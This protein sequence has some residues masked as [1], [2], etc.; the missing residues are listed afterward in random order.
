LFSSSLFFFVLKVNYRWGEEG[1][2]M[3][4]MK[5]MGVYETNCWRVEDATRK[6]E[7]S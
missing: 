2:N 7:N 3:R 4:V 6:D 5:K 1:R